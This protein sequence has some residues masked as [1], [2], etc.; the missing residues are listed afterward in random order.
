MALWAAASWAF[1]AYLANFGSY[2]RVYGSL[3]AVIA[4]LMWFW[5]SA[6]VVLLGAVLDAVLSEARAP[7]DAETAPPPDTAPEAEA[8]AAA[9]EG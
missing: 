3:G 9:A 1:S 6:F 4:L 7:D 5:L 2:D 8:G